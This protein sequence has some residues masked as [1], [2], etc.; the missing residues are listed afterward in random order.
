M[1]TKNNKKESKKTKNNSIK[2]SNATNKKEKIKFSKKHPKLSIMND[3]WR[4]GRRL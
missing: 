3:L 4:M 2:K 1:N